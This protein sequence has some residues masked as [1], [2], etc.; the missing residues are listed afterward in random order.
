MIM[1][2]EIE[3]PENTEANH[4]AAIGAKVEFCMEHYQPFLRQDFSLHHLSVITNI[5]VSNLEN[6]FNQSP[7][8][9]NQYL[10]EWRVKYAKNLMSS[11]KVRDMEIKTIGS[12]SGFSSAKKFTEA[13]KHIE[14]I[15]PEIDQ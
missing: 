9:F 7:Q 14:G 5:P 2:D 10:D 12:L 15:L 11:G 4:L 8:S 13:F 6:Y 1:E 3:V